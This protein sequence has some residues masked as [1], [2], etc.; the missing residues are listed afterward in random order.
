[1]CRKKLRYSW[2]ALDSQWFE[3]AAR[4]R[5]GNTLSPRVGDKRQG[6]LEPRVKFSS[7]GSV[8][9]DLFLGVIQANPSQIV[10]GALQIKGFLAIQ[11][12]EG[13]AILQHFLRGLYLG[14]E[15]RDFG[16][17]AAISAYVNFP[18][19][20]HRNNADVLDPGFRAVA[21][22]T[23]YGQFDL[24]RAAHAEKGLLK[25]Y[26]HGSRILCAESAELLAHAG[27]YGTQILSIGVAGGHVEFL[28]DMRQVVLSHSQQVD[29][30]PARNLDHGNLIFLGNVG[31]AA[32]LRWTGHSTPHAGHD[33]V[34][35]I[36]LDVGV[37][38]LVDQLG[39]AV[40]LSLS[41]PG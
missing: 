11:L 18:A 4:G 15:L 24:M 14:K 9:H 10:A 25:G 7:V 16:L 21:R 20:F 5:S 1:S 8:L 23:G 19:G 2:H 37:D 31:N 39:L 36:F 13:P 22:A 27:L 40:V 35:A 17:D 6:E 33:R 3:F 38:A 32:Q 12:Q 34:R 41:G 30:L 26:A 29:A 28:P